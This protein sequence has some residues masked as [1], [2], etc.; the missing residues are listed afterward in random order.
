MYNQN[1]VVPFK[2]NEQIISED[3][4]SLEFKTRDANKVN[5]LTHNL[6]IK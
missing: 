1:G 2:L 5:N 6:K 4:K 3:I